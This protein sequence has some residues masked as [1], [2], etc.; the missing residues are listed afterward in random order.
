[1]TLLI[2]AS[3]AGSVVVFQS[4]NVV[5]PRVHG[6]I[7]RVVLSGDSISSAFPEILEA[8]AEAAAPESDDVVGSFEGPVHTG[9]F[10]AGSDGDLASRFQ[11]A[12]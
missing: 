10:E 11:Y 7:V 4:S 6:G 9:A 1:M 2:E 5:Q 12:G 8:T 3:P